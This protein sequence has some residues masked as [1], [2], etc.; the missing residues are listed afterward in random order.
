MCDHGGDQEGQFR[1]PMLSSTQNSNYAR[2]LLL[3]SLLDYYHNNSTAVRLFTSWSRLLSYT[4]GKWNPVLP[5]SSFFFF[6]SS[7]FHLLQ[8][9]LCHPHRHAP[10]IP[11]SIFSSSSCSSTFLILLTLF[12]SS[13]SSPSNLSLSHPLLILLNLLNTSSTS[14]SVTRQP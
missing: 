4:R 14:G 7:P 8:N 11:R 12:S 13:T 10:S 9:L 5:S 2:Q 6:S 1:S 3:L